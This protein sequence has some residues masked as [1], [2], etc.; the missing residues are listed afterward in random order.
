[1][2]LPPDLSP[3]LGAA[4]ELHRPSTLPDQVGMAVGAPAMRERAQQMYEC[5]C[6]L[7]HEHDSEAGDHL[8]TSDPIR[9]CSI[10]VL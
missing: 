9:G 8:R 3:T 6:T 10:G 2:V 7:S 5:N 4:P 1:M